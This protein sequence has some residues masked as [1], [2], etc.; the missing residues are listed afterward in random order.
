MLKRTLF[1]DR[2]AMCLLQVFPQFTF[3]SVET[4]TFATSDLSFL[5]L[6]H[7]GSP[8][9]FSITS[10]PECPYPPSV[11]SSFLTCS[12]DDRWDLNHCSRCYAAMLLCGKRRQ[13]QL[14]V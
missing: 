10:P 12:P 14:S 8:P 7:V 3:R 9:K 5:W 4:V 6:R 13:G 1:R 2:P 11:D